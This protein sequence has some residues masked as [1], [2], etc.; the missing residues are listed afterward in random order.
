MVKKCLITAVLLCSLVIFRIEAATVSFLV[1][2]TGLTEEA[3]IRQHSGL[4]ESGLL[5]VFF[6]AGHI[7][8]NAPIMRI[9]GK[10]TG[11]IPNEASSDLDDAIEGG[12]DYFVIAVLD[13]EN[14]VQAP[15][16]ISLRVFTVN[17]NRKIYE[18]QYKGRLEKTPR[19]DF[20]NIKEIARGLVPRINNR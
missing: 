4:W 5:D 6:E 14:T 1:I 8:S 17:P 16:N 2:E 20:E 9:S 12:A 18:Q 7:V 15:G 10:P 3:A 19:E 11:D 13:Y